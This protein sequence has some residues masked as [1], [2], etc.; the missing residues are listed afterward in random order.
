MKRSR[1]L[2]DL[3]L[4]SDSDVEFPCRSPNQ[5]AAASGSVGGDGDGPSGPPPSPPA[6]PLPPP[7]PSPTEV[8]E[9]SDDEGPSSSLVLATGA[10]D[11]SGGGGGGSGRDGTVASSAHAATP[12]PMQHYLKT[13]ERMGSVVAE[14]AEFGNRVAWHLPPLGQDPVEWATA[15]IGCF[16]NKRYCKSQTNPKNLKKNPKNKKTQQT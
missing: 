11:G 2:G 12:D 7:L 5:G 15:H 13:M 4:D 14:C 6:L 9:I 10:G 1:S 16:S 3:L 8:V